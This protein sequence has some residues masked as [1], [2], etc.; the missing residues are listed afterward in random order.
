V[1][2]KNSRFDISSW[3]ESTEVEVVKIKVKRVKA[4]STVLYILESSHEA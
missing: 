1:I 2:S 4:H 3:Y